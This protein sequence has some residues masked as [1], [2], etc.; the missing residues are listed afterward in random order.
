MIQI[1]KYIRTNEIEDVLSTVAFMADLVP[2]LEDN[3]IYWKWLIQ[4]AHNALQGSLVCVLSGTAGIGAFPEKL[5]SKWLEYF[6]K[7]RT[8]SS[9]TPPPER[10][11]PFKEL[12]ARASQQ[13]H[14]HYLDGSPLVLTKEEVCDLHF[15]NDLLRNNFVH[16]TPGGW[17]IEGAG[18]PRIILTAIRVTTWIMLEH[19]ACRL[20]LECRQASSLEKHAI[21]IHSVLED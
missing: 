10:L 4:A 16:F 20:K 21:A 14:M 2:Q 9:I 19:P 18:L 11:A 1:P 13:E 6:E 15:L 5:Q 17:S 7:S 3:P 12:L 8:D